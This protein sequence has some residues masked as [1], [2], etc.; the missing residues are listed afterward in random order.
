MPSRL[1]RA[2]AL[3]LAAGAGLSCGGNPFDQPPA[4]ALYGR[5]VRR[6]VVEVAWAP[7][8]T[9]STGAAPPLAD[10]WDL[11]AQNLAV[12]FAADGKQ[13]EVPRS[14]DAMALLAGVTA[15]SFSND[16]ILALAQAN[17]H[18]LST[19]S[20]ATFYVLYL[21]GAYR[22]SSGER[23]EVLG[24]SLDSEGV[25]A[26]FARAIDTAALAQPELAPFIEQS[27]LVHE[28][29]HAVGLVNNGIPMV[30]PHEDPAGRH[31]TNPACVM[32]FANE[33]AAAVQDLVDRYLTDGSEVLFGQECLDDA[34]AASRAGGSLP[35]R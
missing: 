11:L 2:V 7:G 31:C 9:P 19:A 28:L 4:A 10:V 29:G 12:L 8:A 17:R 1:L 23:P 30:T 3:A 15:T 13:I 20:T 27:T 14:T 32:Y 21:P 5:A 6:L 34:A 16:D 33:G 26:L 35:G 18:E 24:V 22:D 25:V